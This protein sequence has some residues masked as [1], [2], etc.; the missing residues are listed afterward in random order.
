[1]FSLPDGAAFPAC[2]SFSSRL[3][4]KHTVCT[5]TDYA[6]AN[7]LQVIP[8]Q[9]N[10]NKCAA[11]YPCHPRLNTC[12]FASELVIQV[13]QSM[14]SCF[15]TVFGIQQQIEQDR[16]DEQ[17]NAHLYTFT[18]ACIQKAWNRQPSEAPFQLSRPT[19]SASSLSPPPLSLRHTLSPSHLCCF[20]SHSTGKSPQWSQIMASLRSTFH[21]ANSKETTFA[22]L[23]T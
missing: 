1:M 15:S 19:L 20:S 6:T 18:R 16:D 13:H 17:G 2:C 8:S 21:S 14:P 7:A 11:F 23:G 5:G 3:R 9:S 10:A 12:E 22:S 4:R